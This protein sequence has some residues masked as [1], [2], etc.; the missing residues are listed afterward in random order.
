MCKSVINNIFDYET[1]YIPSKMSVKVVWFTSTDLVNR[2]NEMES[3]PNQS[4]V[5]KINCI[6]VDYSSSINIFQF[7]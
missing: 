3:I 6:N 1:N 5:Y 4:L 2:P 7:V